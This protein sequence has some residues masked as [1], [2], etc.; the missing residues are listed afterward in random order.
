MPGP[1]WA[2]KRKGVGEEGPISPGRA[3]AGCQGL[4]MGQGTRSSGASPA[5][6]RA[7]EINLSS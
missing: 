6:M 5:S 4:G 3:G 2:T 7:D 1:H